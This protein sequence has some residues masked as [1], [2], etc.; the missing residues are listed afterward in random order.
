ME[1]AVWCRGEGG[2]CQGVSGWGLGCLSRNFL[3][4]LVRILLE[5]IL[6][7]II[8]V[9]LHCTC[10]FITNLMNFVSYQ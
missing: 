10:K 7:Q 3:P 1:G 4:Q 2:V 6:V 9:L 5:C 8:F